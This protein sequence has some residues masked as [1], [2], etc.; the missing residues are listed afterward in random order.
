MDKIKLSSFYAQVRKVNKEL[1]KEGIEFIY[2]M[3][4]DNDSHIL[5]KGYKADRGEYISRNYYEVSNE[6]LEAIKNDAEDIDDIGSIAHLRSGKH[7]MTAF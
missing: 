5:E 6:Q 4:L 7:L 2:Y 3:L 1:S